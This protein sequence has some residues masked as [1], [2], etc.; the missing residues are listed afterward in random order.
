MAIAPEGKFEE[1]ASSIGVETTMKGDDYISVDFEVATMDEDIFKVEWRGWLTDKT[2]ERTL[3]S[4]RLMG[5]EGDDIYGDLSTAKRNKVQIDVR[6]EE[7]KGKTTARVAFINELNP[8]PVALEKK[9]ETMRAKLRE[10][11]KKLPLAKPQIDPED[12]V[13]F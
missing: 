12:D 10:Q 11:A 2:M 9:R 5:W 8:D 13:G 7:Y 1:R 6:H 4:L 3:K